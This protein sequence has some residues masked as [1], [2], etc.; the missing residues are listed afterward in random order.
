MGKL[1]LH[2][3]RRQS[4]LIRERINIFNCKD[5]VSMTQRRADS[6]LSRLAHFS[7]F[8]ALSQLIKLRLSS[9]PPP[10]PSVEIHPHWV[11]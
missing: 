9:I 6:Y 5:D 4:T 2:F 7:I 1:Q 10:L 3:T 11:T 8:V